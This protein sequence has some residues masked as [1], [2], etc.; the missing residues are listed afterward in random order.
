MT[1]PIIAAILFV[2]L[3]L[4]VV[5]VSVLR[6]TAT[7]KRRLLAAVDARPAW[8]VNILGSLDERA[9]RTHMGSRLSAFLAGSGLPG[10]SPTGFVASVATGAVVGIAGTQPLLGRIGS[11]FVGLAI[12][13]GVRR[14][15]EK[16]RDARI[17]RFIGQL[18]ELAR[19]LANGAQAGLGIMRSIELAAREMDEPA[20]TELRQVSAEMSV[21]RTL[22]ASLNN[23]SERLP[24]RELVVLV[25]TLVIQAKSGGGL[26]T[27]LSNIATTL[28]ERRQ[29]RREIKTAVVGAA[30]SG[31]A[32]ILI[33]V[34]SVFFMNVVSPGALDKMV[35]TFP[36]QLALVA[37]ALLFFVGF[38]AIQRLS[39]VDF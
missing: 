20:S 5:T 32:V 1:I 15:L 27:A 31:Y 18:P 22:G 12:V 36:G 3:V 30:F 24:S 10:W 21:G 7:H 11:V 25:Q 26:V 23:L 16:R 34:G 35:G 17:E 28:E 39:K 29:L 37:A 8:R 19:L 6:D 9:R 2:T 33:G 14:S 13:L 4:L 38:V